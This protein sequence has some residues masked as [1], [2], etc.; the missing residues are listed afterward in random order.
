[1]EIR[2]VRDDGELVLWLDVR[3]QLEPDDRVDLEVAKHLRAHL[4]EHCDLIAWEGE[5]PIGAAG[6]LLASSFPR[7][8]ARNYV[9]PRAQRRGIGSALYGAL[10]RWA[11]ER[12]HEEFEVWIEDEHLEGR[13]FAE[14]RGYTQVGHEDR[15]VL[16]LASAAPAAPRPEGIEI[17]T[18]ADHP[19]LN[20]GLYEVAREAYPDIPG[21]DDAAMPSFEEWLA[22]DMCGPGYRPDAVFIALDGEQV[23]GYA[24]LSLTRGHPNA[25]HHEITGVRRAWRGRG[26]AGALKAAQIGWAKEAGYARL[27]TANESRNAPIQRL[28]RR[29]GYRLAPGRILMRGPVANSAS[30]SNV[31]ERGRNRS[32]RPHVAS[33]EAPTELGPCTEP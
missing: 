18:W 28:N 30:W 32:D 11:T 22:T 10:S 1:M 17:V 19:E 9:L 24:K 16:E 33:E 3:A 25:A 12:E 6:A 23:V 31:G 26:I 15:L 20:T 13:Q 21:A 4:R 14:K 27:I 2:R 5:K 8:F 7:P 29:L